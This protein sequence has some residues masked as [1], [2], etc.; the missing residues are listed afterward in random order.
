MKTPHRAACLAAAGACCLL[1][2]AALAQE[3]AVPD[4]SFEQPAATS[5]WKSADAASQ[6]TTA[7]RHSGAQSLMLRNDGQGVKGTALHNVGQAGVPITSI[8][9]G[10]E[11]VF[12]VFVKAENVTGVDAGGKPLVVLRWRDAANRKLAQEMYDWAPYGSYDF[13][14]RILHLQAPA[15]ATQIDIG[16]RSWWDCLTG[17]TY[18]DDVGFSPRV[19]SGRGALL[20]TH[21]AEAAGTRERGKVANAIPGFHGAGYF[22]PTA[23]GAALEWNDIAGDGQRV[24]AVRYS[25]EGAAKPLELLV[26]GASLG[27]KLPVCTGRRGSYAT[28]HWTAALPARRNTV[29]LVIQTQGVNEKIC[30]MIDRLEV[31]A[32][33]PSAP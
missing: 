19:V 11:Y 32:A 28:E 20:E 14:R 25:W 18:W 13:Q 15:G 1:A 24:L 17:A 8:A 27:K 29:R 26:N 3:N 9:P 33:T 21:E 4:P 16:F 31:Y 7:H 5:P 2:R 12:S 6:L 10:R 23:S 22:V 30:P